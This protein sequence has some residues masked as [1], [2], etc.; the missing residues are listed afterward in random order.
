LIH[1]GLA[2]LG[3]DEAAGILRN[4]V[5]TLAAETTFAEYVDPFTGA[6]RG[7]RDF[8]WTAALTLDLLRSA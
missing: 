6:A 3:Y 5:L 2:Q 7:A 8:S 1:R 4:D